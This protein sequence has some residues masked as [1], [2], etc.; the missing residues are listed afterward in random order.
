MYEKMH[1]MP[2]HKILK[3]YISTQKKKKKKH[4]HKVERRKEPEAE[5]PEKVSD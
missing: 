2:A 3:I 4:K 5:T 1:K